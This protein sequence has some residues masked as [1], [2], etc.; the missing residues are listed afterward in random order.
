MINYHYKHNPSKVPSFQ[1]IFHPPIQNQPISS[2]SIVIIIS[3]SIL[4]NINKKYIHIINHK[5]I[6]I[7]L[8]YLAINNIYIITS[9]K[10]KIIII[11]YH[12]INY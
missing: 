4:E 5:N 2:K 10:I 7:F 1:D 6:S 3:P 9:H 8:S 11:I 12:I